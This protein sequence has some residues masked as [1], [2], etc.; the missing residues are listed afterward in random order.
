MNRRENGIWKGQALNIAKDEWLSIHH[1]IQLDL[2]MLFK[3]A[4]QIYYKGIECGFLEL[5]PLK[6]IKEKHD[7]VKCKKCGAFADRENFDNCKCGE[8]I[9]PK[10]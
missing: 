10:E 1:D 8:P 3:R 6:G 7:W 9:P 5:E 4:E 2:D